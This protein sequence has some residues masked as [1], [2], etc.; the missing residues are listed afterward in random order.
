MVWSTRK[1][2]LSSSLIN[3]QKLVGVYDIPKILGCWTP[4]GL[5]VADPQKRTRFPRVLPYR[6]WTLCVK[7]WGRK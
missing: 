1:I 4:L 3:M 5:G 6:I 7:P 2:F